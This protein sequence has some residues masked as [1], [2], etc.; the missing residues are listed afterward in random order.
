MIEVNRVLCPVDLSEA[1]ARAF[2]YAVDF[3][4]WYEARLTALHVVA[5]VP[6][7]LGATGALPPPPPDEEG[8]RRAAL[9]RFVAERTPAGGPEIEAVV[10]RGDPAREIAAH[11]REA[12]ADLLVAGTHGRSG[13]PRWLLG[14]VTEELLRTAPCPLLVVPPDADEAPPPV[15]ALLRRILC[16]VDFSDPSLRAVELSLSLAQEADARVLLLHVLEA[17]VPSVPP[18]PPAG[19]AVADYL[20][21]LEEHAAERLRRVIPEGASEWCEPTVRVVRGKPWR[22]IVRE[23]DEHDAGL[24]VLGVHGHG[25]LDRLFFGSTATGVVRHAG[26]PVLVARPP[27]PA[28]EPT[29]S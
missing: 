25:T 19:P 21:D 10:A 23:A 5:P 27:S 1:S 7:M 13:L 11:A 17:F 4:R 29:A 3:A 18:L 6:V 2:G 9:S 20:R 15:P 14:S 26:C 12:G 16:A 8:E 22:E 24:I 28:A